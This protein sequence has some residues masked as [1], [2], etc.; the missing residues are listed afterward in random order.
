M[1]VLGLIPAR[2]GSK[3]IPRK[4]LALLAG[5]PLIAYTFEAARASVTL[6][7]TLVSTDDAELAALA[8]ES[9]AE[10]PFLRP[11]E[12]AADAAPMLPVLRHALDWLSGHEGYRP[13]AVALLQ[14]TSP[15][16]RAE[17]IDAAVRLLGE[18]GADNVVSVVAVPHQFSPP[19]V[20]RFEGG[21]LVPF[22]EGGAQVL[23]RQDKPAVFARNGPAVLVVRTAVLEQG[24]L[25]GDDVR[26]LIMEARESVDIDSAED[27]AWAEYLLQ[28]GRAG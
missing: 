4:N 9:G 12:L 25:Y 20:L 21:R 3:A 22:L 6:D 19:S 17:H 7:R 18:T 14:P 2:G 13:D 16:R 1:R 11:P 23:R 10:A 8:R 28:R 15:L 24:R 5:Q 26:P 27:L